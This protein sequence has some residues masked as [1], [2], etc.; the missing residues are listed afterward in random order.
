MAGLGMTRLPPLI[1]CCGIFLFSQGALANRVGVQNQQLKN[2]SYIKSET[3]PDPELERAFRN[4][5][6]NQ[7]KGSCV[8]EI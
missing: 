5:V 1:V 7:R 3:K 4:K 2:E 8:Y 6:V